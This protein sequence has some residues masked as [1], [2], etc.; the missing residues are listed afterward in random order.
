[1]LECQTE[2]RYK[3][4]GVIASANFGRIEREGDLSPDAALKTVEA[5]GKHFRCPMKFKAR[6]NALVFGKAPR[7]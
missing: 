6:Q 3:A 2:H 5:I 7:A 4:V 1:V